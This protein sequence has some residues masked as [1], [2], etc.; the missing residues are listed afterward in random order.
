MIVWSQLYYKL[1]WKTPFEGSCF[2]FFPSK[3]TIFAHARK[4]QFFGEL[5]RLFSLS[6]TRISKI[7]LGLNMC[8][9][10]NTVECHFDLPPRFYVMY[11]KYT[12]KHRAL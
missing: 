4:Y 7:V 10:S 12:L 9:N 3:G 1:A 5:Y 8:F 11:V 6:F 2:E